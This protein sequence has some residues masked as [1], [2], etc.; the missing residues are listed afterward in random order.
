MKQL[1]VEETGGKHGEDGRDKQTYE[2]HDAGDLLQIH[3][4]AG[5]GYDDTIRFS[6]PEPIFVHLVQ[7][8][9]QPDFGG[10]DGGIGAVGPFR[11]QITVIWLCLSW[12]QFPHDP[13][14]FRVT[15]HHNMLAAKE[16]FRQFLFLIE[17]DAVRF[18]QGQCSEVRQLVFRQRRMDQQSLFRLQIHLWQ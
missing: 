9:S 8:G 4:V 3:K 15:Y 13:P 16:C 18:L 12:R 5:A 6:F 1:E 17:G 11:N 7:F 14:E 2:D 10:I